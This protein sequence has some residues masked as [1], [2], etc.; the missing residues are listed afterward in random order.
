M[1]IVGAVSRAG[2]QHS[3]LFC[4]HSA[5]AQEEMLID[6]FLRGLNVK[7]E[8]EDIYCLALYC[9]RYGRIEAVVGIYYIKDGKEC[10][11]YDQPYDYLTEYVSDIFSEDISRQ[12][13]A[14]DK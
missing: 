14:R 12:L 11:I 9:N 5:S 2:E 10:M 3:V 6:S 4:E 1:N 8:R 7:V 13:K